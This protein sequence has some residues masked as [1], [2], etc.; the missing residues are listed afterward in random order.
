MTYL[1]ALGFTFW[2]LV[3]LVAYAAIVA[4]ARA[5]REIERLRDLHDRMSQMLYPYEVRCSICNSPT[6]YVDA[7]GDAYCRKHLGHSSVRRAS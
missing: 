1:I 4:G 3:V 6:P 2:C 7:K 5:D